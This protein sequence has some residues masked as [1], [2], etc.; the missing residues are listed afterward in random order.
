MS[1][2]NPL[3]ILTVL[4]LLVVFSEWVVRRTALRHVGSA[5]VVIILGAVAS[6]LGIIPTT[7]TPDAPVPVYDV[8]FGFVAPIAIF[9]LLLAVNLR[10]VLKAG[11][12][13]IALFAV[14]ALGTMLGVFTGMFVVNGADSIGPMYRAVGGMFTGT[15]TGGSVNFNAVALEYGVMRDGLLYG[16]TVAVDNVVTAFWIAATLALPRLLL[17]VWRR[18]ASHASRVA[19]AAPIVDVA[20]E[21]ETIDPR[22]LALV[23]ALGTGALWVSNV[24][25]GL[26]SRAGMNV[27]S[28]LLITVIALSLAQVRGV[29]TLP[30]ARVAGMYAVY[31]FLAV[32]GAFCDLRAMAGLGALGVTLLIFAFVTV[33]VHGTLTF[34]AAWLFR[35]DLDG[36][37]VASQANVGGSTSALAL[38][39][40]L[41]REDLLLPGILLGSLGN[42]MGTF[43]GFLVAR[44]L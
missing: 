44:M 15:Y 19:G 13:L 9:W 16:G 2:T 35:M 34:G 17:P 12:P 10:D 27:P 42:A 4:S 38:A 40:S 20:A 29:S 5:L 41:G 37:A 26:L 30:G 7:S 43:L 1:S 31:V 21:T 28:I 24:I 36:A 22:K 39:K 3:F 32:I 25:A 18:S 6:N 33:L 14:G 23:L 8:V 11:L